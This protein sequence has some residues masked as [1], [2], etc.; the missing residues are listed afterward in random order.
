[1][2]IFHRYKAHQYNI[3][4]IENSNEQLVVIKYEGNLSQNEAQKKVFEPTQLFMLV[5]YI[6]K[7]F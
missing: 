4:S 3:A 1:M 5:G 7:V 6:N 2:I